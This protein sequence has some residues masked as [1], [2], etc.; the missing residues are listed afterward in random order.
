LAA[1]ILHAHKSSRQQQHPTTT[2][3]HASAESEL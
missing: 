1:N 2:A 3:A